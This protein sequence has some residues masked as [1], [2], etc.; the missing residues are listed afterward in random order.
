ML[1]VAPS[2]LELLSKPEIVGNS[3]VKAGDNTKPVCNLLK[4]KADSYW[5]KKYRLL[6]LGSNHI[7]LE[8]N[9]LCI[10]RA[11]LNDTSYYA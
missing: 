5:W 6:L 10:L 3:S 2:L 11:L 7:Q 8:N 4:G 1:T 9:T